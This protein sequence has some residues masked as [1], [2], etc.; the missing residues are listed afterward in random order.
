M[1]DCGRPWGMDVVHGTCKGCWF[2]IL[3]HLIMDPTGKILPKPEF[4]QDAAFIAFILDSRLASA[5][6]LNAI[7]RK[8]TTAE[9]T[10]SRP[11]RKG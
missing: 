6:A 9:D 1:S 11:E 5:D 4:C 8:I 3:H 10:A 2:A 7:G